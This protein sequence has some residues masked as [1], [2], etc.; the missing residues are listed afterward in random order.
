MYCYVL[1]SIVTV[2]DVLPLNVS[3][4]TQSDAAFS[5][6]VIGTDDRL[7][8]VDFEEIRQ[9]PE[10]WGLLLM[11]RALADLSLGNIYEMAEMLYRGYRMT[12]PDSK[13]PREF[14][15]VIALVGLAMANATPVTP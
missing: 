2:L 10:G 1:A 6:F 4:L 9:K 8:G 3:L 5:N 13:L 12:Q 7:Y 14:A 15:S 11:A